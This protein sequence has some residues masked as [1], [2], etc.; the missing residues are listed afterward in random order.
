MK[1]IYDYF[2]I[3]TKYV[4]VLDL[5]MPKFP[6]GHVSHVLNNPKHIVQAFTFTFRDPWRNMDSKK[7]HKKAV[8]SYLKILRRCRTELFIQINSEYDM[9]NVLHFHLILCGPIYWLGK[10]TS[11]HRK[12]YGFTYPSK[13]N[14]LSIWDDYINGQKT[15]NKF[16]EN[17]YKPVLISTIDKKLKYIKVPIRTSKM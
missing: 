14:N 1:T 12:T 4:D 15:P 13:L 9:Q 17:V 8:C 16:V 2:G 10:I 7:L 6:D 3:S 5:R 11:F